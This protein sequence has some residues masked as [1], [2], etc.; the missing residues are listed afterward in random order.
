MRSLALL[1]G[2]FMP[3]ERVYPKNGY[4]SSTPA[5][6]GRL[7]YAYLGAHGAEG[8]A[9]LRTRLRIDTGLLIA[10]IVTG[11]TA[12]IA[13]WNREGNR[14]FLQGTEI[15]LAQRIHQKLVPDVAGRTAQIEW[16]GVS[17]ASSEIG[18]DLVD[19][20]EGPAG[21]GC[22][23]R[24]VRGRHRR[25]RLNGPISAPPAEISATFVRRPG[26]G[27][28]GRALSPRVPSPPAR[29]VRFRRSSRRQSESRCR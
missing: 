21:K 10:F 27:A 22:A 5:T 8:S 12:F 26:A 13:L 17:R 14:Y 20:I 28:A 16:A 19:A 1:L 11:F 3:P 9:R 4:A 24:R 25:P 23:S 2:L 18:G 29:H 7:V 15:R 6:D